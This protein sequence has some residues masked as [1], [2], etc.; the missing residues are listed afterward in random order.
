VEMIPAGD[1][2]KLVTSVEPI[3]A[4]M[5]P[6]P[7][8]FDVLTAIGFAWFAEQKVDIA[9]IETGLGGRLDSTNVIRP[10][11][12]AITSISMDHMAQLGP[13]IARISEEKAGIF[14]HGVPAITVVQD[15]EAE[16]VLQRI[17]EKVGAPLDITGK[18]IEFSYR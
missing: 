5:K 9:V 15:P 17:A 14:K 1:C 10:E 12:T 13:T 2:S 18:S 4:R 8:C 11:V 16:V 6:T 7:T 3:V